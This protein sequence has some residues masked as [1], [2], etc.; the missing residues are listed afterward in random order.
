MVG[1]F[2]AQQLRIR[3]SQV[4]IVAQIIRF[5]EKLEAHAIAALAAWREFVALDSAN[6]VHHAVLIVDD[7]IHA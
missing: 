3:S 5:H 7:A 4:P 1:E 2:S 6:R